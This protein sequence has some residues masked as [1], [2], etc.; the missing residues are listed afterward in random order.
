MPKKPLTESQMKAEIAEAS[1]LS[2]ADVA[3]VFAATQ[4]IVGDELRVSGQAKV[5]GIA[6]LVVKQRP[7]TKARKG[8]NPF[9]GAPMTFKAKP[10]RKVVRARPSSA[11]K[12]YV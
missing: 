5:P 2:K 9:T 6:K 8:T 3:K 12:G 1:G 4:E 11:V 7:A 10:A